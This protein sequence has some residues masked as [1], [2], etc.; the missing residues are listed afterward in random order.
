MSDNLQEPNQTTSGDQ[1]E[2][3]DRHEERRQ[4][5]E[6]RR[7]ARAGNSWIGGVVLILVGIFLLLQNLGASL[8]NNWWALFI[9]I[10][11]LGAFANAWRAYQEA[12]GHLTASARSS[13]FGGLILTLVAAIFLFNLSWGLLGPILLILIGIGIF[14]NVALP[15]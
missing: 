7:A 13:L 5:R 15:G 6:E 8:L 9:L 4:H 11:A 3:L 10:P 1:P 2:N 12:G 14:V